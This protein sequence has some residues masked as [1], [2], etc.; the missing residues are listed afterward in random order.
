MCAP[1]Q[2]VRGAKKKY[3]ACFHMPYFISFSIKKKKT[4][5]NEW[6]IRNKYKSVEEFSIVN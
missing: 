2:K 1:L 5:T 6:A 4:K 3:V